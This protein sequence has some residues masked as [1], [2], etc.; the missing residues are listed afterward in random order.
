MISLAFDGS[1]ALGYSRGAIFSADSRCA[2]F[3]TS[4]SSVAV[5]GFLGAT[6]MVVCAD[7]DSP[8]LS[9]DGRLVAYE[10]VSTNSPAQIV[11]TDLQTGATNLISRNRLGTGGGNGSSTSP[12]LSWDGRFVVFASKASD[13]VDNDVNNASDIFVHDRLLGSTMLVSL[14]LQGT[15]SGNGPS[16]KPALAADGRTEIFRSF[17]SAFVP[18]D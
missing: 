15:G 9:A 17:A 3:V 4:N 8:S 2:A 10:V 13:L 14:N 12:L 6:S 7:C 18:G 16:T 1:I 5:Y 11:V